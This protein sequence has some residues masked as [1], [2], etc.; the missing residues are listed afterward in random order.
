EEYLEPRSE[1]APV[2]TG[3]VLIVLSARSEDRLREMAQRFAEFLERR[4]E[5]NQPETLRR[6]AF[7]LQVGRDAFEHRLALRVATTAE[8]SERLRKWLAGGEARDVWHG[9][10]RRVAR[11]E[12]TADESP[13]E[14]G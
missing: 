12:Q 11:Q 3:P 7:T 10:A 14:K 4:P 8:C 2:T 5:L 6:I 1:S 9:K 13:S